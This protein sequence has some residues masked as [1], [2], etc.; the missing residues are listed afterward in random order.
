MDEEETKFTTV[1]LLIL[2]LS[3]C[4]DSRGSGWEGICRDGRHLFMIYVIVSSKVLKGRIIVK[5][6]FRWIIPDNFRYYA[7]DCP[8]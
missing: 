6:K 7:G 2:Q 8:K 5:K 4:S 1:P 3:H